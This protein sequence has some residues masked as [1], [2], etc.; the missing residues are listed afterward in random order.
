MNDG[1]RSLPNHWPDIERSVPFV[2]DLSF[3]T[4]DIYAISYLCCVM[5]PR[6]NDYEANRARRD[7]IIKTAFHFSTLV[8]KDILRSDS[9]AKLI[10]HSQSNKNSSLLSRAKDYVK[11]LS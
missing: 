1:R 6:A 4:V 3:S 8:S 2:E 10:V 11:N 5:K 9:V 7:D